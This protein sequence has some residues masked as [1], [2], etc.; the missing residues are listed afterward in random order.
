MEVEDEQGAQEKKD[1]QSHLVFITETYYKTSDQQL[2]MNSRGFY[3]CG[4]ENV[5]VQ[6]ECHQQVTDLRMT[7]MK[8]A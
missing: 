4:V 7:L 2:S 6:Y 8:V 1:T 3:L 5:R